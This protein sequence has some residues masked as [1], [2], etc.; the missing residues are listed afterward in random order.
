MSFKGIRTG[1]RETQGGQMVKMSNSFELCSYL[2]LRCFHFCAAWRMQIKSTHFIWYKAPVPLVTQALLKRISTIHMCGFLF[3]SCPSEQGKNAQFKQE[4]EQRWEMKN[5]GQCGA[6][7]EGGSLYPEKIC[8]PRTQDQGRARLSPALLPLHSP[9]QGR[10]FPHRCARSGGNNPSSAGPRTSK[11]ALLILSE[12]EKPSPFLFTSSSLSAP[13]CLDFKAFLK[14]MW[15]WKD[16]LQLF[17]FVKVEKVLVNDW[18][19]YWKPS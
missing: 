4:K 12:R 19:K 10:V 14:Q 8:G 13:P 6:G 15:S 3:L 2:Q 18:C 7:V 16:R 17:Y 9:W 11:V 1:D 5:H